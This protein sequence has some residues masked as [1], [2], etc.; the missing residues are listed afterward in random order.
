MSEE[1][2]L[3]RV[4]NESGLDQTKS[5]YLLEKFQGFFALAD[6]WDKKAH[7]IVIT[8]VLQTAEM[9]MAGVGRKFLKEKRNEIEKARKELK[10][11]SLREGR[12]VD[13]IANVLKALIVPIEEHL[14]SQEKYAELLSAAE[15]KRIMEERW[16]KEE[17]ERI[18]RER[19]EEE[20]NERIRQENE[21]L[22]RENEE[23]MKAENDRLRKEAEERERKAAAERK[24]QERILAEER[25][26]AEA[27]R[28]RIE[29]ANR[30]ER[31][32]AEKAAREA[33]EKAEAEKRAIEE[34]ARIERE[35]AAA[36]RKHQE[37]MIAAAKL[38]LE[39]RDALVECPKCGHK[40]T[41]GGK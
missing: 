8:S 4:I 39:R 7:A 22:R 13:G 14:E 19:K 18:E 10:E 20:E 6:E 27:E 41:P 33:R 36:I 1:N 17:A 5:A 34:K 24:E 12:G 26:K 9:K 21:R 32:T 29:E 15:A 30:K 23:R 16:A 2:Q 28:K 31:E 37:S 11:Q 38:E 35:K 3:Q 25:A 40:F